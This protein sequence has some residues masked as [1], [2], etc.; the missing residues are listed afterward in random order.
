MIWKNRE[1]LAEYQWHS[2]FAWFPVEIE[3]THLREKVWLETIERRKAESF[4]GSYWEYRF[5]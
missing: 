1:L 2:W 5:A 4:G 3:T